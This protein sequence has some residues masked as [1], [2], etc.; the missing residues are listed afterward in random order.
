MDPLDIG[1][2][3]MAAQPFSLFMG[4]EVIAFG[5]DGVELSLPLRPEFMNQNGVAHGGVVSY[6]ADNA[7]TYA[8]GIALGLAVVTLEMK[9]NYLKPG[10]GER[11][12][13]RARP[14]G[15]GKSQAVCQCEVFA[16]DGEGKETLC[17]L[18]QGTI[19][20]TG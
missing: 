5:A 18:A 8:G 15:S 19:W 6:M 3:I 7:L 4:A 13:A 11:L 1:R 16:V 20:K 14:A 12:I 9:I 17:A 10:K 2:Q